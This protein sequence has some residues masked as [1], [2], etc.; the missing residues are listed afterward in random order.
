MARESTAKQVLHSKAERR[1]SFA[2][3]TVRIFSRGSA[4][5]ALARCELS[6]TNNGRGGERTYTDVVD[7]SSA[8]YLLD[9]TSHRGCARQ[10]QIP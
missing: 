7:N 3:P 9:L 6:T 1:A 4:L 10:T 2:L 5:R 8:R